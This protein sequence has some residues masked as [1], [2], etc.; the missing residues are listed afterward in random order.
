MGSTGDSSARLR[1]V[2]KQLASLPDQPAHKDCVVL[3]EKFYQRGVSAIDL[4]NHVE[5]VKPVLDPEGCDLLMCIY[6]IKREF[7]NEKF[8]MFFILSRLLIR[9]KSSLE[10]VPFI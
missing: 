2:K 7:R 9:S 6:R 1:W 10:N 4:I 5:E 3:A 8:V